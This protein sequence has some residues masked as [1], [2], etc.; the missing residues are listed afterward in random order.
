M[1]LLGL[2]CLIFTLCEVLFHSSQLHVEANKMDKDIINECGLY[3]VNST[4]IKILRREVIIVLKNVLDSL[5]IELNISLL[6][7]T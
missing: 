6:S 2:P 3:S 1:N 4:R 5:F 7:S